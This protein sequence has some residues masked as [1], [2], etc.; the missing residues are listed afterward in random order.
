MLLTASTDEAAR[1]A[2][3][4]D[5]HG[6]D[7]VLCEYIGNAPTRGIYVDGN[8]ANDNALPQGFLVTQPPGSVTRPHFHETNQFQVFV[9]GHARFGKKPAAPLTVQYASGHTPYG[10]IVAGEVLA[11]RFPRA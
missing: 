11:L 9:D 4:V 10:P 3:T 8:E 5:V 2:R 1:R 7:Y 6:Q